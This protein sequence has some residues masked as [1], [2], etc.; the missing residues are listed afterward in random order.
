MFSM[1]V[2]RAD[3]RRTLAR[4]ELRLRHANLI[5]SDHIVPHEK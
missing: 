5:E 1:T 3:G 2:Q 4:F